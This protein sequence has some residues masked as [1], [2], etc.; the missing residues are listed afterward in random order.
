MRQADT[1]I[2]GAPEPERMSGKAL[3]ADGPYGA[4]PCSTESGRCTKA[5][6]MAYFG[7]SGLVPRMQPEGP[8]PT[9]YRFKVVS[10]PVQF[11]AWLVV[12]LAALP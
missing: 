9:S 6:R 8:I 12:I 4:G 5:G 3:A 7:Q 10:G 11:I 2:N 1:E